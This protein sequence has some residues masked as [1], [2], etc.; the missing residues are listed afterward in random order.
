MLSGLTEANFAIGTAAKAAQ[1]L[2]HST[3]PDL[4]T[5]KLLSMF[6]SEAEAWL[7]H[8]K[9]HMAL[10]RRR[11]QRSTQINEALEPPR[12]LYRDCPKYD[13]G[14]PCT[15]KPSLRRPA[16]TGAKRSLR[17]FL[18]AHSEGTTLAA[19]HHDPSR[20]AWTILAECSGS[21]LDEIDSSV[22]EL[23]EA[24]DLIH[25]ISESVA[26]FLG[27]REEEFPG[28]YALGAPGEIS[29]TFI[30]LASAMASGVLGNYAHEAVKKTISRVARHRNKV[31][32]LTSSEVQSV[33]V[34]AALV[35]CKERNIDMPD[36]TLL[37]INTRRSSK[38]TW[39]VDMRRYGFVAVAEVPA[40]DPE[41]IPVRVIV[42]PDR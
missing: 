8:V 9:I 24:V 15:L 25:S 19:S 23:E 17:K 37:R 36:A 42:Y 3:S 5:V 41:I 18:A 20:L 26:A 28:D 14:I 1:A 2:W 30:W 4:A 22:S 13:S 11:R 33:A 38:D 27:E 10:E 32:T 21:Q 6:A 40:K 31:V 12:Q 34:F 16:L 29:E 7:R 35:H 39:T